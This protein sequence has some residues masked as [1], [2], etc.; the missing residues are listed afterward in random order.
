[1]GQPSRGARTENVSLDPEA[2]PAS[3]LVLRLRKPVAVSFE[4][5]AT[6]RVEVADEL[7]VVLVWVEPPSPPRP[8]RHGGWTHRMSGQPVRVSAGV[9]WEIRGLLPGRYTA[10]FFDEAGDVSGETAFVVGMQPT[11][12]RG[13]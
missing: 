8:R 12:V 13:P 7:E 10:R 11:S 3:P 2:L 1:M 4:V 9:L 6:H 5:G